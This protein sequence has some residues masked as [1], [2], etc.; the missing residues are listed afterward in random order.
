MF[1]RSHAFLLYVVKHGVWGSAK[2]LWLL[3]GKLCAADQWYR[4]ALY[5]PHVSKEYAI[6]RVTLVR[7]EPQMVV[8]Y[9]KRT[10]M[11]GF[12]WQVFNLREEKVGDFHLFDID[13]VEQTTQRS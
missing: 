12:A 4:D 8:G 13:D 6:R 10:D 3:Y 9:V 5:C 2:Q 11:L 7:S 1:A